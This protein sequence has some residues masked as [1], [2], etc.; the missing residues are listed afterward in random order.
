MDRNEIVAAKPFRG[1]GKA[2][3]EIRGYNFYE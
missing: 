3:N 1:D 2:A